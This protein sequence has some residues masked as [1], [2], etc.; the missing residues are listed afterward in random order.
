[1]KTAQEYFNIGLANEE[2]NLFENAI[3]DYTKA[4]ELDGN[5]A[6]YYNHR[7]EV[8]F[9]IEDY[10][11]AIADFDKAI[12]I[13][14]NYVICYFNR[15]CAKEKLLYN[16]EAINDYDMAIKLSPETPNLDI[17]WK[18]GNLKFETRDFYAAILDFD[19][20]VDMSETDIEAIE[21]RALAK[22]EIED[23]K[24]ALADFTKLI[25]LTP[26]D[27][28][29]YYN[30]GNVN[31]KLQNFE[32]AI[33]DYDISIEINSFNPEAYIH[34]G[35]VK[36]LLKMYN[37]SILD[38]TK[39]IELD[40]TDAGDAYKRRSEAKMKISDVEGAEL[41]QEKSRE[42]FLKYKVEIFKGSDGKHYVVDRKTNKILGVK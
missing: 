1:M 27:T 24:G 22:Y 12:A 11:G 14:E 33:N 2:S 5:N 26:A 13:D 18:R 30:R 25:N 4:I 37:E 35:Q 40:P 6:D 29:C 16:I 31:L 42:L 41:D 20:L 32:D 28:T 38:F 23:F 21:L 17:Y 8:K 9:K 39:A 15:G 7:G 10:I 3:S 19:Y 36:F 34:R